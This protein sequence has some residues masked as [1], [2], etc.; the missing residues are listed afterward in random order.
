MTGDEL[1][2]LMRDPAMKRAVYKAARRYTKNIENIE[3]Y[4]DDAWMRIADCDIG[5]T[6]EYYTIES[7][8]AV[9]AAYD[10]KRYWSVGKNKA[11][12]PNGISES[13]IPKRVPK[14]AAPLGRG[15]YLVMKPEK[16]SQWYYDGEWK[17][18]GLSKDGMQ[19][20]TFYEI[21]VVDQMAR[22]ERPVNTDVATY[23]A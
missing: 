16:L 21:V 2:K 14:N 15:R 23:Q 18:Y 12:N 6:V 7:R 17:D 20:V 11:E 10:R 8:R 5:K 1:V 3:E 9:R 22:R 4:M 13:P 19:V